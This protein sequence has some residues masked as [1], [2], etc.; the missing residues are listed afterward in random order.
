MRHFL[1]LGQFDPSPLLH[2]LQVNPSLWNA[3]TIRTR[4]PGT[5]HAEVSD[6]LMRFND[7]SEYERTG[8]PKTITDDRTCHEYPAWQ[9]LPAARA[10][11]FNLM[12]HVEGV[13]LGR[14]II[15]KLAPGKRI[16]P[17]VD[18]GAP[19]TWYQRYQ[20]AIQSIPGAIFRIGEES[21]NFSS[22]DVWW[23]DNETEHEV[24]N[25]SADDR[26]VMIVDIRVAS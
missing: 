6:I 16:T 8:D 19:A 4:H 14:V 20:L 10:P 22:G 2:Q 11:I 9:H 5:A 1:K 24:M 3:N 25:N 17:H 7:V 15:T 18:G 26:I 23:I 13:Q 21:V 12:R